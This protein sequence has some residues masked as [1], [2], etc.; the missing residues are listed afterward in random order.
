MQTLLNR[1]LACLLRHNATATV[2]RI[3]ASQHNA[4]LGR[5]WRAEWAALNGG[6]K[7]PPFRAS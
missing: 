7:R 2:Y 6:R 1:W 4:V 3:K 5:S